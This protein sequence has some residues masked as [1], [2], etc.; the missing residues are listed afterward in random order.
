MV[1]KVWYVMCSWS[2]WPMSLYGTAGQ[3]HLT[4][5]RGKYNWKK[6]KCY[7]EMQ[8]LI[9]RIVHITVLCLLLINKSAIYDQDST[10]S[11]TYLQYRGIYC[12]R[13]GWLLIKHRVFPLNTVII[14]KSKIHSTVLCWLYI[15]HNS[16]ALKLYLMRYMSKGLWA[17]DQNTHVFVEH[18]SP[19]CSPL[20]ADLIASTQ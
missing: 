18:L 16:K 13:G 11:Q 14:L 1:C 10:R 19:D 9:D 20:F 2:K 4:P 7:E 15:F 6:Q 12:V 3:F 5:E 8:I 17:P